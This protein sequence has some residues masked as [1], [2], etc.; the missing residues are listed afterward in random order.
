MNRQYTRIDSVRELLDSDLKKIPDEE[1]KR[2]A[3]VHLYGVGQAAALL[4]MKRGFDRKTAELAETA[5]ML[6]D[7]AKYINNQ[8]DNHAKKSAK[9]AQE[10]LKKIPNYSK[11]EIDSICQAICNHSKKQEIGSAFDEILKDADEIQHYF[12]NPVE[13]YF[14]K[15]ERIQKLLVEFGIE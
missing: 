13:D 10:L 9:C 1:V 3:Y 8:E 15:K 11:E 5:G 14:F 2:C 6:H 12:R 4:A 7:Y